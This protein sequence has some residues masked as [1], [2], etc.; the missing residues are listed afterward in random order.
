MASC[1]TLQSQR[2]ALQAEKDAQQ[3]VCDKSDALI[4]ALHA[5][6]ILVDSGSYPD[7]F[8]LSNV[9]A[10][11]SQIQPPSGDLFT[12]YNQCSNVLA[13]DYNLETLLSLKAAALTAKVNE[14]IN[15]NPQCWTS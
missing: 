2:D 13:V 1:T 14:G 7:P 3:N 15:N 6:A 5:V 11:M 9:M 12:F 4:S 10:R 8:T